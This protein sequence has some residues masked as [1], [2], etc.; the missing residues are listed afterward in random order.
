M[1]ETPTTMPAHSPAP[2]PSRETKHAGLAARLWPRW[3]VRAAGDALEPTIYRFILRYSMRDQL[4][5]VVATL[6][7]FPFLYYSL[8][9][10]K[11]IINQAIGGEHFPVDILGH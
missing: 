9:L 4:Y 5:L 6:L 10:P 1:Q 2:E 3:L 8:E 11:L 7:S